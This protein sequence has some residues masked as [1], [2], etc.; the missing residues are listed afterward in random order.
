MNTDIIRTPMPIDAY[1]K[2]DAEQKE[3]VLAF[4]LSLTGNE[5]NQ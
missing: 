4:I 2:L 5:Y 3:R 1:D